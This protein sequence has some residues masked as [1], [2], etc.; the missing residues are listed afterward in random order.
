MVRKSSSF[1]RKKR[2]REKL[3]D[4]IRK[5]DLKRFLQKGKDDSTSFRT[6]GKGEEQE[7]EEE[8]ETSGG[9]RS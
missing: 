2:E 9:A 1:K 4:W 3:G 6:R 7:E 5:D 8:E